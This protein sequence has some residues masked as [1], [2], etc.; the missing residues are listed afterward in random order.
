VAITQSTKEK[1]DALRKK[2]QNA[3]LGKFKKAVKKMLAPLP[4][5]SQKKQ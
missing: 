1:D 3:D 4:K 2:L 5:T